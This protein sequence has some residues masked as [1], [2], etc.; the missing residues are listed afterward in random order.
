MAT[1]YLRIGELDFSGSA[2][3][4]YSVSQ[5]SQADRE[6]E[7]D[8]NERRSLMMLRLAEIISEASF[9]GEKEKTAGHHR[10]PLASIN[11]TNSTYIPQPQSVFQ[12]SPEN[13]F[14][15]IF[16]PGLNTPQELLGH[17]PT[18]SSLT[19]EGLCKLA[20]LLSP[21]RNHSNTAGSQKQYRHPPDTAHS[22]GSQT[23]SY[24]SSFG[25]P[26]EQCISPQGN[27][28][29]PGPKYR[30]DG[31]DYTV[32]VVSYR[33]APSSPK[34]S[35]PFPLHVWGMSPSR[36]YFELYKPMVQDLKS[37]RCSDC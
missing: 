30:G 9:G 24:T 37:Q 4:A 19:V 7:L 31:W 15:E 27:T 13:Q 18:A 11:T 6:N 2:A 26:L 12:L 1:H 3:D 25:H 28:S 14:S 8:Q 33:S 10:P 29:D 32:P 36:S 17:E 23:R 34:Y 22:A 5:K 16:F 21:L 35:R 20:D